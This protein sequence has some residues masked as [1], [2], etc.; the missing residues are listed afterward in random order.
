MYWKCQCDCGTVKDVCGRNLRNG[1][2]LS[3]GCSRYKK[4]PSDLTG[5]K[6]G[7]LTVLEKAG[8]DG[9]SSYWKCKCDCGTILKVVRYDLVSGHTQSCGCLQ[10]E[11]TSDASRRDDVIGKKFGKLIVLP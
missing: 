9:K 10:K 3:C 7:R 2:S 8:T 5:L 1:L 11:R 6:F 4:A